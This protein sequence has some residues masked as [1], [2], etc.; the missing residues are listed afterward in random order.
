M[1]HYVEIEFS[2]PDD[3]TTREV[4][5][6]FRT[7]ERAVAHANAIGKAAG[8]E[9]GGGD[10]AGYWSGDGEFVDGN[11]WQRQVTVTVMVLQ[12]DQPRVRPAARRIRDYL[13]GDQ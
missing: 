10:I 9:P 12:H 4:I 3:E 7:R 2:D 6:A 8:L 5:G 11:D 1:S 13:K